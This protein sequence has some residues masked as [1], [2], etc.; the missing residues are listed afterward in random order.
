MRRRLDLAV[1]LVGEPRVL[2]LDE[3]TTGLDPQSR[4]ELWDIVRSLAARGVTVLLTTQYMEEAQALADTVAVLDS[5]QLIAEGS[6]DQLRTQLGG[7]VL[8]VRVADAAEAPAVRR[9]LSA[10]GLTTSLTASPDV[11]AEPDTGAPEVTGASSI[12]PGVGGTVVAAPVAGEAELTLAVQVLADSS[13]RIAMI[14]T[15]RPSL[16]EVFLTLT[17]R[18]TGMQAPAT[19]GLAASENPAG[20]E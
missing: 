11:P 8:H 3:P 12:L 7:L 2:F 15:R 16:D 10:A 20:E 14:E 17:G 4:L 1:S 6:P 18:R 5:G 9:L 13:A 19:S